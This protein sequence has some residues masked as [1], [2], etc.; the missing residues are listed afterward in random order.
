MTYSTGGPELGMIVWDVTWPRPKGHRPTHQALRAP[1]G[2]CFLS[3]PPVGVGAGGVKSSG[4]RL[5]INRSQPGLVGWATRRHHGEADGGS[6]VRRLVVWANEEF[7]DEQS[8][9][10]R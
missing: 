7:S 8:M 9:F 1:E 3:S 5:S 10:M 6:A 2:D 4:S